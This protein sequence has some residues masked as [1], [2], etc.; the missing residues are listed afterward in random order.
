[1][2]DITYWF[3]YANKPIFSIRGPAGLSDQDAKQR[4]MDQNDRVPLCY[5]EAPLDFGKKL[6]F[7]RVE[8]QGKL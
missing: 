7:S 6:L 8:R 1:M 2:S 4:A 3:Y 5:P